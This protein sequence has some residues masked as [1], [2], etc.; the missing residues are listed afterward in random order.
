METC[1][2]LQISIEIKYEIC[3]MLQIGVEINIIYIEREL[4]ILYLCQIQ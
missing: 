3:H 4:M 2:M 1:H